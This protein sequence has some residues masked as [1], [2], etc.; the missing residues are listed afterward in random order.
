MI[1]DKQ[2]FQLRNSILYCF[3]CYL[4]KN[5]EKKR[6]VIETLLP[7]D[8]L[9]DAATQQQQTIKSGQILCNGLFNPSDCVSNW[10][11][12]VALAHTI[13]E[14]SQLKEQLL[15]VQ[16]A[17]NGSGGGG[18]ANELRAVALMDQC[19][20]ILIETKQASS[21]TTK[22]AASD[23]VRF[24]TTVAILMLMSTWLAECP[25]AVSMFLAQQQNIPYVRH[26]NNPNQNRPQT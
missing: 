5:E 9:T 10:L 4:H 2:P 13:S 3:E 15:R 8:T 26:L 19:M 14:S 6:E 20:M 23:L 16:L 7:K 24:Q 21:E 22:S 12:A 25:L 11:C 18:G 17:L 1:N